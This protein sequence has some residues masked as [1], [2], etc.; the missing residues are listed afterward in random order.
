[1]HYLVKTLSVS[2]LSILSQLFHYDNVDHMILENTQNIN[3]KLI[4]IFALFYNEKLIGEL[5][6]M[7]HSSDK[8]VAIENR[9]AYLFAFRIH[10]DF[11]GMGHGTYLLESVINT[12]KKRGYYEF[13]IGVEDDNQ[14]ANHIY[15]NLGFIEVIAR[16][17]ESYQGNNCEYNLLLRQ[18]KEV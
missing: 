16:K 9:R 5:H 4:D 11:Q 14:C 6:V 12:L 1:M 18:D 10:N 3:S 15:S 2:E 13:T 7:Y 17:S 8:L